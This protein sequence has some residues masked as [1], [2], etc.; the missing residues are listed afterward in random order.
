MQSLKPIVDK[1]KKYKNDKNEISNLKLIEDKDQEIS[2]IAEIELSEK[3]LSIKSLEN[4]LL[5]LLIP[6]DKNDEKNSILEIRA[7]TGGDEA[8]LFAADLLN[9]YQRFSDINFGTLKYYLFLRQ[10]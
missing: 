7:G 4:E 3:K 9:M 10:V 8:S 6:K 2:K 5:R 1:I